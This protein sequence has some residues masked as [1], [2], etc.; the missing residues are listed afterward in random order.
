MATPLP[1]HSERLLPELPA[2]NFVNKPEEIDRFLLQCWPD[3]TL[4]FK[5]SRKRIEEFLRLCAEEGLEV[6]VDHISLCG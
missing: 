4:R 3:G 1:E 2:G 5:S 6:R